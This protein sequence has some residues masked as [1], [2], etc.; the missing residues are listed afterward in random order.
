[1]I[2]IPYNEQT[3]TVEALKHFIPV[4]HLP[5]D[6]K[7]IVHITIKYTQQL[8]DPNAAVRRGSALALGVLPFEYLAKNWKDLLLKL[9]SSC[10]I[11]VVD[12]T[13]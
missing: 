1:M 3:V 13:N 7:S 5:V 10:L 2:H 11:E 4:Y 6:E 9:C 12:M 8:S